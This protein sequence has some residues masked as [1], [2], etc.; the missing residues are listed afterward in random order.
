MSDNDKHASLLV[1]SV[2]QGTYLVTN[3]HNK[4][5]GLSKVSLSSSNVGKVRS[6]P[7]TGALHSERLQLIRE[8]FIGLESPAT[9]KHSSLS[10][11]S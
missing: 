6:L 8:H 10:G 3:G 9:D 1:K 7:K 2:G 4:L 5:E 11:H